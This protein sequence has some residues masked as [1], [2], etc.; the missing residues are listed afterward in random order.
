M[1]NNRIVPTFR[2]YVAIGDSTTEG[3]VDPDGNGG[4][5]GWADRLAEHI[6]AGQDVPVEYANL[7]VRGLKLGE[8][9]ATQFAPAMALEP[10]LLT[11]FGGV[12]DAIA[13]GCDFGE[14]A[15]GY[16]AMFTE[17][18]RRDI[19][20]LTFTMP[21]PTKIN[22]L[23]WR[24]RNRILWLNDIIRATA[25]ETGV[26]LLDFADHP[27]AEDQRLWF[28]DRLHGN[29]LGHIRVAA[30]LAWRLGLA[31]SDLSWAEP[32]EDEL[33]PPGPR[34]RVVGDV[35]W[36]VR[37]L[38][39]WVGKGLRRVPHNLGVVAKRPVPTVV[40]HAGAG[41]LTGE[42]ERVS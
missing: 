42:D 29:T 4:Y 28:E 11:V 20:V 1:R 18:R 9:R 36:A 19:T 12:N 27:V 37:H 22:P 7:A 16:L 38:A 35:T 30:A 10:D 14:I 31:G 8:I 5:R 33:V 40:G 3:L 25:A 2:R 17:A 32:L 13:V 15:A 41:Q 39:P 21:D 23:G 26:L 24:M 6:A 34:E